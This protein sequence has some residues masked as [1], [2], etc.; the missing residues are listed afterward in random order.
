MP[1]SARY[2]VAT[3]QYVVTFDGP[4]LPN[5][6]LDPGPW[7]VCDGSMERSTPASPT[8]AGITVTGTASLATFNACGAAAITYTGIGGP[9]LFGANGF[10]VLPF[11]QPAT[12]I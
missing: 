9:L 3:R 11:T 12:L 6:A 5:A 10:P 7:D 8:A 2:T 1:I 4:L